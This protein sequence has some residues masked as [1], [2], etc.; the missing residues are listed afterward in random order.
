MGVGTAT[1]MTFG[2][3]GYN[4]FTTQYTAR[5]ARTT[6]TSVLMEIVRTSWSSIY[7]ASIFCEGRTNRMDPHAEKLYKLVS[8]RI[9][10]ANIVQTCMD[11]AREIEQIQGMS[12]PEK[13]SLLQEV[14]RMAVRDRK[15]SMTEKEES[16]YVIDT[17]VPLVV[18]AA[19]VASKHPIMKQIQSACVGCWTKK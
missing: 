14:L 16:L 2:G 8:G 17:V 11:V 1:W 10:F 15:V 12:G 4:V 3:G 5:C 18:R 6:V 7:L 19:I 13:L 9:D